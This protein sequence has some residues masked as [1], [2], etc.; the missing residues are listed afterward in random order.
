VCAPNDEGHAR[1]KDRMEGG[2]S[3]GRR[4][5]PDGDL[6]R[7]HVDRHQPLLGRH[8]RVWPTGAMR[9]ISGG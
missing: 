4:P 3:A 6:S 9:V 2:L 1:K 7:P 5:A 8:G